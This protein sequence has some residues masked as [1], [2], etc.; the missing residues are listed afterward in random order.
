MERENADG[1]QTWFVVQTFSRAKGG[2][3]IDE[4]ILAPSADVARLRAQRSVGA[5]VGAIAFSRTGCPMSGDYDDAKVLGQ[6]GEIPFDL[7][8]VMAA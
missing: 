8:E 3:A 1:R 2:F 5:K 7:D 4:P 6:Y